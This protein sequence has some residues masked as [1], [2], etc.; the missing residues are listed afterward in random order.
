MSQT[1]AQPRSEHPEP[2]ID[3]AELIGAYLARTTYADLPASV[4]S[5]VKISIL[6]MLG[7]ILAGTS[8]HDVATIASL[9]RE[10]GGAPTCTAIVSGVARLAPLRGPVVNGR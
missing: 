8:A 6:D 9:V 2:A 1:E 10:R 4:V 5:A 7:C 3:A